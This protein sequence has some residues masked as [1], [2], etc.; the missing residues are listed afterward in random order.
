MTSTQAS[1][2]ANATGQL[3]VA[4]MGLKDFSGNDPARRIAGFRNAVV[5]GRAVTNVLEHLR[6]KVPDFD[7][8]YK[9]RSAALRSDHGFSTLYALRSQILKEGSGDPSV[10]IHIQSLNTADLRPLMQNPPA[11]AESF[12]IGDQTG[13]SGWTILNPDG[14]SEKYYVTLPSTVQISSSH[15]IGEEVAVDL[16]TRYLEAM[17][18]LITDAKSHFGIQ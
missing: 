15:H 16:L 10:S 7:A 11:G 3:Q 17:A 6:S 8:W 2:I 14:E 5:F 1:V 13:G 9:P 12:F 4:R 18:T